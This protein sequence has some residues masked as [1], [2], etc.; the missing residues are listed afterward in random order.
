MALFRA[1][2]AGAAPPL[3]QLR[4]TELRLFGGSEG[5]K[6]LEYRDRGPE[7]RHY[8]G[9]AEGVSVAAILGG[10]WAGSSSL[11]VS[12]SNLRSGSGSVWRVSCNSRP[13]VV[14]V[15]TSIICMAANFSG[16]LLGESPGASALNRRASV[17][18][19][20]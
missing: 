12:S 3:I 4:L 6:P 15:A 14:G 5:V 11:S 18:C 2:A 19:R 20:Q 9:C 17:A 8:I 1:R 10:G 13:S 16:T 7:G